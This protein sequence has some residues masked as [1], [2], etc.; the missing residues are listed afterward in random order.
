MAGFVDAAIDAAPQMLDE[1][2]E[3][4]AVQCVDDEVAVGDDAGLL[5]GCSLQS[6]TLQNLVGASLHVR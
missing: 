5:H 1:G 2:A 6:E 4:A 3:Y